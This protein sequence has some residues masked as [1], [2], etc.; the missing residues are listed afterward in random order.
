MQLRI[1][2]ETDYLRAD[3][4]G[5]E[6]PVDMRE[7]IR[8]IL[9]ECRRTGLSSVLVSTRASRPLFKVQEFGLA[10]FLEQMSSACKV[11][12]V[13]DTPELRAADE[14][15][16]TMAR[17]KRINLRAFGSEVLAARWLRGAPEPSRRYKFNRIVIAG[18]PSEPGVYALW[19]REELIYYG[20]ALGAVTIRSRLME[21]YANKL[22]ATHYSWEISRQPVARES[23][24]LREYR[25]TF[26]RLPRLNAA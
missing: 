25:V 15:L 7:A 3:L 22:D 14:Y 5:R 11:A 24:L 8:K 21:H 9:A 4:R 12:L 16:A 1:V 19:Q 18:A 23:E 26:G 13:S 17:Q 6:T 20:R 2:R 10:A